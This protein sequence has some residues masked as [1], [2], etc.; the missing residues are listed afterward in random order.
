MKKMKRSSTQ[1][2]IALTIL[3][4][5]PVLL[6]A[7]GYTIK[8]R[9]RGVKDTTCLIA[10]YYGNGTYVK[11]TLKV[12]G[13]GRCVFKAKEDLPK[14]V[15]IV[16]LSDKNYFEFVVNKDRKF[17]MET[18]LK[19]L[20]GNMVISG[21]P[22]NQ[23]FYEYL[24]YNKVKYD[25]IQRIQEKYKS[26]GE[27]KDSAKIVGKKID[28]I[29]DQIIKYKLSLVSKNP[30]S[31]VAFMINAMKEPEVPEIPVLPNGRKDSTFAYRYYKAHYWDGTDFTDDRLLRTPVFYS[32]LVKYYDKVII[33][34]PDS[35]INETDRL[36]NLSRPNHEMFKYM[37][38]FTTYHYENSEIMGFDKIFV[39][40]VE[41][42][43]VTG[44]ADWIN[45]TV[46]EN[47]IKKGMKM[48]PLLIG[49]KAPN[50]IM[51][52][53]NNQLVSMYNI[54]A[55]Y[56]VVLFWDPDC[57]HCEQEI[58]KIRELYE[59][60]KDKYGIK[61]FAVCSDSSMVKF[62]KA[63]R[64]KDMDWINV[65]GPRTLTGDFH[66]SYDITTTPVT[67]LLNNRKEILAKRLNAEQLSQFLQNYSK[68]KSKVK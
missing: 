19:N 58:P 44:Q 47:I 14:G 3:I 4:V 22:E 63:I 27:N 46:L 30:D 5:A 31:F 32:K 59:R 39:H 18:D 34:I 60:D 1:F 38:W 7:Q 36:I 20:L 50:M 68:A 64:K 24:K 49:E 28:S 35:I 53:T 48:K 43:Y 17:S 8:F 29:N 56:L 21:S 26:G 57:G 12:D 66:D 51:M 42:Y 9:I 6:F 45:K 11:D 55:N 2:I 67:Y 65:D 16:V 23:L 52:D 15:Y 61:I 41:T 33:Q 13:S 40:I 37:V 54:E 10:N 62:K 25:D